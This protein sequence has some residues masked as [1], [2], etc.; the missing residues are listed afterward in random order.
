MSYDRCHYSRSVW[1]A[2]FPLLQL[3]LGVRRI[4][5]VRICRKLWEDWSLL[6]KLISPVEG[7]QKK[8]KQEAGVEESL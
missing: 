3:S 1:G 8:Q 5:L 7:G 4:S 6:R 2:M